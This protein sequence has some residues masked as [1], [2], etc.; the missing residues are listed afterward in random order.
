MAGTEASAATPSGE[1]RAVRQ[2]AFFDLDKTVLAKSSTL[3]FG[4]PLYRE[5]LIS[6][7]VVARSVYGQ[8]VLRLLGA[9]AGRME[10]ARV[11]LLELTRGWDAERV[12]RLVRETLQETIDPLVYSEAL[13]LFDVHRRAG[14]D[15]YLVSW[16]GIEIVKPLAEYLGVAH[17]LASRP[18]ID[19]DGRYDGTLDFYCYGE[20]KAKAIRA[21]AAARGIDLQ[22]SYAYS[23]S[24]TDLP[25]L[26]AVGHPVVVNPDRRLRRIG[27]Q[28]GWGCSDFKGHGRGVGLE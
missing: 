26:E 10:R 1:C 9:S 14:R 24:I 28:R 17:V 21:E 18:G 13:D 23:D 16:S 27:R 22:A 15:L 20:G 11:S 6:P 2:A 4:R 8:L 19:A 3:A 25:M 7:A 12:Q 5:G